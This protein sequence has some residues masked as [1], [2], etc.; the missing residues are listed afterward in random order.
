M[1]LLIR[2][3]VLALAAFG[4]KSLYDRLRPRVESM[5]DTGTSVVNDTLAPA[6]RDA[7]QN[8]RDASTHAVQEVS[9]AAQDAADQVR[10]AATAPVGSGPSTPTGASVDGGGTLAEPDPTITTVP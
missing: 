3:S 4:A 7:A 6:F 9:G 10:S 1:K 2:L 8:V 5:G